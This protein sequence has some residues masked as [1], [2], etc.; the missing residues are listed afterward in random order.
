MDLALPISFGGNLI[1]IPFSKIVCGQDH[2]E[3]GRVCQTYMA[4][5]VV[6][7]TDQPKER[8]FGALINLLLFKGLLP[9]HVLHAESEYLVIGGGYMAHIH[10]F[11]G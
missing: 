5:F 11:W 1:R 6:S 8:R 2:R 10:D 9:C 3:A 4:A 7:E